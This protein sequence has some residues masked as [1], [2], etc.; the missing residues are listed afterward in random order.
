LTYDSTPEG[1]ACRK[2]SDE[3]DLPRAGMKN[4]H[5]C[6]VRVVAGGEKRAKGSLL[7]LLGEREE[8]LE[9]KD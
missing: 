2:G 1:T 6:W 9:V 5:R 7:F 8:S 3:Y 4:P